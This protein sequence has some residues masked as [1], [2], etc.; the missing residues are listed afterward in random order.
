MAHKIPQYGWIPALPDVRDHL[1]AAPPRVLVDLP[2]QVDLRPHC[3]PVLDQGNLGSCTAHAIANAHVFDQQQQHARGAFL[4][5]SLFIYYNDRVIRILVLIQAAI[6]SL[7]LSNSAWAV[8]YLWPLSNST[9]PDEM[10][11]SFGPRINFAKWDFHDGIDLPASLGTPVHAVYQGTVHR[12]GPGGCHNYSSRHIVLQ[13]ND[14]NDVIMY[15]VYLHLD[16]IN[17]M[18]I[19]GQTLT[20]TVSETVVEP[21][22][23]AVEPKSESKLPIVFRQNGLSTACCP[24]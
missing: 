19:I 13:V 20:P 3:P 8:D 12:A 22:D 14:P 24:W 7:G 10:N 16:S 2:P 18:S 15:V 21:I 1:Y 11:T 9:T 6:W 4:P 17:T 23:W 5:S